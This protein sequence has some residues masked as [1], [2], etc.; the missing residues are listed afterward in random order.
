MG[1]LMQYNTEKDKIHITEYGRNI[2]NLL[3]L[4]N[5]YEDRVYR[6]AYVERVLE[7]MYLLD[8]QVK[9]VEDYRNKLWSHAFKITEYQL[10]V[11]VPEGIT[12]AAREEDDFFHT[13]PAPLPYPQKASKHRH[14]GMHLT[15]MIEKALVMPDDEKRDEF[16]LLIATFMKMA[17]NNYNREGVSDDHI[18]K[19]LLM[20]SDGR[21]ALDE[22][23]KI[24]DIL[25]GKNTQVPQSLSKTAL[26]NQTKGNVV[27]KEKQEQ[28]KRMMA[29][30]K[31][32]SAKNPQ[33]QPQKQA[34][35]AASIVIQ[36]QPQPQPQPIEMLNENSEEVKKKRR[37]GGVKH[38]K[39]NNN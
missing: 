13:R 29:N 31:N 5:T 9:I 7:M 36:K 14:Y 30:A 26:K 34:Q 6:T 32:A 22:N 37:R 2:Q 18:R 21:L 38:K 10:D 28:A 8:P 15:R 16:V 1:L 24:K 20:L 11:D 39:P 27:D 25:A 17:Q 4:A 23:M 3:L 33:P 19:D 12:I 35:T